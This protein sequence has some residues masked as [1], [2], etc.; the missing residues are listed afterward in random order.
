MVSVE[1]DPRYMK[2]M[3]EA[4]G[5]KVLPSGGT[6]VLPAV[7]ESQAL[8]EDTYEDPADGD[9]L[10]EEIDHR[11]I[12]EESDGY[13]FLIPQEA[14]SAPQPESEPPQQTIINGTARPYS[15]AV[16]KEKLAAKTEKYSKNKAKPS[17]MTRKMIAPNLE[18]CFSGMKNS[19]KIR[20]SVQ[21][22]LFGVDSVKDMSDAQILAARDWLDAHQDTGGQ[23]T[24]DLNSIFE[25]QAVWTAALKE[26]GQIEMPMGEK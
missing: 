24:P 3:L 19:D 23:W 20:H 1:C 9:G 5:R 14:E 21:K 11:E 4:E 18:M 8:E 13:P 12:P 10:P 16:L 25:A 15:P 22:Y 7:A 2:I 17:E 6:L 26:A